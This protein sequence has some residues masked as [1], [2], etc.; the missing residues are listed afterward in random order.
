MRISTGISVVALVWVMVLP[1]VLAC[2]AAAADAAGAASGSFALVP[3][4][5]GYVLKTP[6]GQ[7]VLRYMTKRPADTAL[8]ANSVC[9]LFPVN[10]PAGERVVDF[11]PSDHPHHRGI[12]LAWHAM[13]G[14]QPA[15]FW[16]WGE[17]APTEG[18][19][20]RSRSVK[21][22]E[23]DAKHAKLAVSNG[24]MLDDQPMIEEATAIT[25]RKQQ[26]AYVIDLDFQLTPTTDVTLRQTAFGGLCVKGRKDGQ[27]AYFSPQGKVDL[28]APHHLKPESD[29]PAAAWYD[30]TIRLENGKTV[31]VAVLDHPGNPPT[32]WHNLGP[33][34]MLNPCIVA[35]GPVTIKKGQP[36][37]LRYRL[38]VHDGPPPAA[39]LNELAGAWKES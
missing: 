13:D 25:A 18:R 11:A 16:G 17:W 35:K 15:D 34:A 10:T 8:T 36:L 22:E 4:E 26:G 12:F 29:W 31:G 20:I 2:A 37:R 39:L 28:P 27:G 21:L 7:T 23:A 38:V 6:D 24:W 33:I 30:Y 32:A 3:D 9:C 19:V 5:L 1:L 14:A